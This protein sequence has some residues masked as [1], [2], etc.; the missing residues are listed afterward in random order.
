MNVICEKTKFALRLSHVDGRW[1]AASLVAGF[2]ITI[3][4]WGSR[5]DLVRVWAAVGVEHLRPSFADMR[6][7]TTGLE[8]YRSGRDP[9]VA[10]RLDP[11]RRPMNYPR[12]WL[13]L[14]R[15][16]LGV[17]DTAALGILLAA[18]FFTAIFF[19]VGRITVTQGIIYAVL[20]CS[21]AVMLG[22]ER[23][24]VDLLI[25]ALLVLAG[26]LFDHK[27]G[28]YC[29]YAL[30]TAASILKLYPMCAFAIGLRERRRLG[31][32]LLALFIAA[33]GAYIYC[34]RKDIWLM[35]SKT[36]QIKEL[37]YGRRVLFQ[38][39][40]AWRFAIRIEPWSKIAALGSLLV[41]LI[42]SYA[43]K[44]PKL[45]SP[46]GTLMVIGAAVYAGTFVVMNNFNYRLIF[47]LFLVPQLLE[48]VK[49]RDAYR[50][51]GAATILII[52]GALLLANAAPFGLFVTK[53]LLNWIA[54][55]ICL[56]VLICLSRDAASA[57]LSPSASQG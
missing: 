23:G 28:L 30:I 27:A 18:I 7:I 45:S 6:V 26:L 10:N 34:I 11:W 56:V 17:K 19:L 49:Q 40:A 52:A 31:L 5:T 55:I 2:L 25:F 32:A 13:Q 4:I 36:P 38:E 51:L 53:E 48:W 33:S 9:L 24:N 21:P 42:A 47:L 15:L 37:S 41:A 54:F 50:W 20:I 14:S 46:A 35:S 3:Y 57:L 1:V 44:R 16:G 22:I 12:V 43:T 29:S 8:T 39:L